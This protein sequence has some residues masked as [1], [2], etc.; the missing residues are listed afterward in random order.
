MTITSGVK[1]CRYR[2]GL[3]TDDHLDLQKL[4]PAFE[5]PK[6]ICVKEQYLAVG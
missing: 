6:D 3:Q 4:K 5:I 1:K 2:V